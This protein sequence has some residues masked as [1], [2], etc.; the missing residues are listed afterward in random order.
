MVGECPVAF[1]S[2]PYE[3]PPF[4]F[5]SIPLSLAFRGVLVALAASGG[6]VCRRPSIGRDAEDWRGLS[7]SASRL[8]RPPRSDGRSEAAATASAAAVFRLMLQPASQI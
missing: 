8:R 5:I 7:P 2:I 4:S 3:F 6:C 1:A